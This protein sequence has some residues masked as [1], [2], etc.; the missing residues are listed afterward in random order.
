MKNS[1]PSLVFLVA[2]VITGSAAASEIY[3]WTDENGNTQYGDR[4][5]EDAVRV[6]AISSRPTDNSRLIAAADARQRQQAEKAE[7]AARSQGPSEKE[8]RGG[9]SVD[10]DQLTISRRHLAEVRPRL[11]GKPN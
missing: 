4:P 3:R 2:I 1:T 6:T 5:T 10:G 7:I 11:K 9:E 8:L